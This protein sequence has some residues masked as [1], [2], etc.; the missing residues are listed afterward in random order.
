MILVE[1]LYSSQSAEALLRNMKEHRGLV[2]RVGGVAHT[3]V[4]ALY[5]LRFLLLFQGCFLLLDT[6]IIN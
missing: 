6:T 5:V 4:V 3:I 2:Q 1:F